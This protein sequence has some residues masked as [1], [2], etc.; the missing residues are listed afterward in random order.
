MADLE[1][2]YTCPSG[3]LI[4]PLITGEVKP[5]GITLDHLEMDSPQAYYQTLK[6]ERFDVLKMSISFFFIGRSRGLSYR[7]I[8]VFSNRNLAY[9][10]IYVHADAGIKRPD[11]LKGKRIGMFDYM[12]S[13]GIWMRGD[14][15][16]EFGVKP[17]DMEWWQERAQGYSVMAGL[18]GDPP[19]IPSNVKL[20]FCTDDLATMFLRREIDAGTAI[21]P[22]SHGGGLERAKEDLQGHRKLKLLFPDQRKETIRYYKKNG[23]YPAHNITIIRESVLEKH[24]WVATSLFDALEESKQIA[25]QRLYSRRSGVELQLFRKQ[26]LEQQREIFGYDPYPNGI[27]A[28]AELIDR[29]QTYLVEQGLTPEKQPW[30]EVFAEESLASDQRF[31]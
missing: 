28:N 8:P 12:Q 18:R 7:A 4:L 5:K 10:T 31:S 9:T 2:T 1:L 15:Q 22:H 20:N 17:E 30:D 24:P 11:Q 16:H 25:L 29:A 13:R 14:L 23:F 19:S 21:L 27:S 6:F 3:D 26:E